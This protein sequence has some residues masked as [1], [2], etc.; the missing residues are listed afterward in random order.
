MKCPRSTLIK[1]Q[2]AEKCQLTAL[3]IHSQ[4]HSGGHGVKPVVGASVPEFNCLSWFGEEET[5]SSLMFALN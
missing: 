2:G 3:L 4:I 5:E 1:G